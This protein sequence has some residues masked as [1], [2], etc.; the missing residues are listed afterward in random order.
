MQQFELSEATAAR[1]YFY[2]HLVDQTDGITPET[3]EGAGQPQIS[4]NGAAFG[5]TSA[6]L[7]HVS[8]G[9]YYVALTAG[10]IDTL[11]FVIVRYDS[12][13]T[14]EFQ[15]MGQVVAFDPYAA[16][17]L[18]LTALPT[19]NPAANGGLPT[20]N[21]SNQV[22]G[23]S[24]N[25]VGSTA[26]VTGSVGSVTGAV[27]SV[28]GAVGSVTGNVGGDVVGS[29]ASVTGAVG[30]VTGSVG[31]NVDGSTASVTGAV[32]S[33]TGNVG[34]NVTGSVGSVAAGGIDA[35]AIATGAIDADALASD[36]VTEIRS[37]ATGTADAGGDTTN[38]VDS[39]R[40]ESDD[41]WNGAWIL[42][43]SGAVANQ[44]RLITDFDAASDTITF[45][46]AA[47]AS[48]GAGITYEILPAGAVDVQQWAEATVNA[49]VSGR[50]DS[51]TGAMAADV[52]TS[53]A[54]ATSAA[55]EIADEVWTEAVAD[56]YGTAGSFAKMLYW[57]TQRIIGKRVVTKATGSESVKDT[58]ES[59]ELYT[60]VTTDDN[61][62][63]TQDPSGTF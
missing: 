20:V 60:I 18:G 61:G 56:H 40:T 7:T 23:V 49:L 34:G 15:A 21:A 45:A 5:N 58:A 44:T 51:S 31:G 27:G 59:G 13:N 50:V 26:S 1:R 9:L 41:V 37:L 22:A 19:A 4:K 30:S 36:A 54:L 57:F 25:V 3:G 52:V 11:G 2:L 43:T 35:A 28:T 17:N 32:G 29:T 24:G 62:T 16:T 48:I 55:D 14:A 63:V 38:V 6:T 53:S 10:E 39:E 42:F 47:T 46:P 12:A 8:N 33:V